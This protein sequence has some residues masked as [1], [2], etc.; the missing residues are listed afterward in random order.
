LVGIGF[1]GL[2]YDAHTTASDPDTG[3]TDTQ[4]R[5]VAAEPVLNKLYQWIGQQRPLLVEESPVAK[6]MNYL[7]NHREPLSRFLD[8]GQL[9]LDN[10][11]SELALRRQV[12]GRANWTF[13][14]SDDGAE[15]NA[16]ATSLIA[17]C[18][19]HGIEPWA[20]LRDVLTLLP[21]W[22]SSAVLQLAP[23]FWQQTR[24]ELQTQQRLSAA[25]LLGR[26][27]EAHA[28]QPMASSQPAH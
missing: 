14:G 19:L 27:D 11:L 15:W 28:T 1:I 7:V 18:Q 8:D 22:P 2:L 5:R 13:C 3:I 20:Y 4:K 10:N 26:F 6:A 23:K 17:S 24:Q 9:R 16:I 25:R 21:A 12:V